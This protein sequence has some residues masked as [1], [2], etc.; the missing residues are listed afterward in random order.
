MDDWRAEL[1]P[2]VAV[3]DG[4]TDLCIDGDGRVWTNS[5][6][7]FIDSR[8]VLGARDVRQIGVGLIE[9]GGGR[10]DDAR[11]IGDA[12]LAGS[13]R[14]HVALPP[15]ARS[16]PLVSLRFPR[17][18]TISLDDFRFDNAVA[19]QACI[20][21]S[22][23]IAG[24][25]GSGKT[26]LASALLDTRSPTTRIVIIEDVA[27]LNPT[28]PHCVHLT[29]RAANPEGG[30]AISLGQLVVES[31]RMRPDSLVLGEVR[32]PEI[33]DFLSALSAGHHGIST[34]HARSVEDVAARV[35]VLALV[36]GIPHAA[37]A[38]LVVSAIPLVAHIRR[39]GPEFRVTVGR[40]I[41]G[42]SGLGVIPL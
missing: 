37:I 20:E 11:P 40:T 35:M 13:V 29:S 19:R 7:G 26:T 6:N 15:V 24:V 34:I 14:V 23:L 8:L 27:E 41:I 42:E 39:D 28:H 36:A 22:V 33:R 38:P 1:G 4:V 2:L 21:S 32:G 5:G 17:A 12:S 30:G 18:R 25:T 31:L 9:R 3:V 10:V 16:G